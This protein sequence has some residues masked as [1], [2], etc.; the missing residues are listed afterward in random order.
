M[1]R[2]GRASGSPRPHRS[3][4]S[5]SSYTQEALRYRPSV[6]ALRIRLRLE[7][8]LRAARPPQVP[9]EEGDQ[10]ER[11]GQVGDVEG[12]TCPAVDEVRDVAEPQAVDEVA[13]ATS[14][15]KTEAD[16]RQRPRI[17]PTQDVDDERGQAE[18]TRESDR[19]G[20]P[21]QMPSE[22]AAVAYVV[23]RERTDRRHG[24]P[25]VERGAHDRLC[26]LVDGE[27]HCSHGCEGDPV[28]AASLH[29]SDTSAD[30]A[31]ARKT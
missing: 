5:P 25:K 29:R 4:G 6:A 15:Q 28:R 13:E 27:R 16:D 9:D 14:E 21:L 7:P 8:G 19:D 1:A 3:R 20:G 18:R 11:H 17:A 30:G 31:W 22:D 2:P 23:D 26:R 12:A 10:T 24:L